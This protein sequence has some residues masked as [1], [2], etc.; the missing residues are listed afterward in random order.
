MSKERKER[1]DKYETKLAVKGAFQ[2][3]VKLSV[4][5]VKKPTPEKKN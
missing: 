5:E 3:L 1:A 4:T 2:K